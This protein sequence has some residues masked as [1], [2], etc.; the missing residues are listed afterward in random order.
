MTGERYSS[1]VSGRD[2]VH[3]III[4]GR[5]VFKVFLAVIRTI[6]GCTKNTLST[7]P[8]SVRSLKTLRGGQCEGQSADL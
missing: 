7:L 3:N 5:A 6:T 1:K 2:A 8:R 4:L